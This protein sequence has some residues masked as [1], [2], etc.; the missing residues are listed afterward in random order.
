[1]ILPSLGIALIHRGNTV[2]GHNQ[3]IQWYTPN[4]KLSQWESLSQQ[5]K[6]WKIKRQEA[7]AGEH[8][9]GNSTPASKVPVAILPEAS[10]F[11][12]YFHFMS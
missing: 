2:P 1:M 4:N 6:T 3:W 5:S 8:I 9:N 7:F 11:N 12:Y 10:L